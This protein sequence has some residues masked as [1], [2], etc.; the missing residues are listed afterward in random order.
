L[1]FPRVCAS[2]VGN[3]NAFKTGRKLGYRL[4]NARLRV[5]AVK[6]EKELGVTLSS[7]PGHACRYGGLGKDKASGGQLGNDPIV[8]G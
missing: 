7:I 4:M 6:A 2:V 1:L 8:S 5:T 3:V